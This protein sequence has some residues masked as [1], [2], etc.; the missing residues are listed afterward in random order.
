MITQD[1]IVILINDIAKAEAKATATRLQT[2]AK[3][4]E[5]TDTNSF[6][7]AVKD[8]VAAHKEDKAFGVRAS[9]LKSIY[10]AVRF[11]GLHE[12]GAYHATVKAARAALK[13]KAIKWDGSPILT[14]EQK[15]E[16]KNARL[17]HKA[18]NEVNKT[19][20]HNQPDALDKFKH[21]VEL[22]MLRLKLEEDE[23][24]TEQMLEKVEQAAADLIEKH[25]MEYA[26]KLAEAILFKVQN[27]QEDEALIEEAEEVRDGTNG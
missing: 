2:F 27:T 7:A 19:F 17:R 16:G 1:S 11:A 4:C 20:N 12:F 9:E 23:K 22:T 8:A 18:V 13:E 10:G 21:E 6:K 3:A 24:H 25:G 14:D 15:Q 5:E 26:I